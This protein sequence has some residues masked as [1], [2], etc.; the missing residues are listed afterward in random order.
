MVELSRRNFLYSTIIASGQILLGVNPNHLSAQYACTSTLAQVRA[1]IVSPQDYLN[2][3]IMCLPE[4]VESKNS[5]MLKG[6]IYQPSDEY[7]DTLLRGL[8]F[9][10]VGDGQELQYLVQSIINS[11]KTIR[12]KELGAIIPGIIGVFGQG[13]PIYVAFE[14]ELISSTEINNDADVRSVIRHELQHVKD[15]YKCITLGEVHLS[16]DTISSTTFRINF[17]EQL[18]EVRGIYIELEDIFRESVKTGR[19]SVSPQ[20]FGGQASNYA[21]HYQ[22]IKN[23]PITDLERRVSQLQIE[24]SKGITPEIRKNQIIIEFNLFGKRDSAE[25]VT[26]LKW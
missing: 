25:I 2:E 4:V 7:L 11:Y 15:W 1:G 24:E 19:V 12:G 3:R 5:G 18:M 10:R 6:F 20:W 22:F 14:K 23:E 8:F 21:E 9:G 26:N 13:I 17:L 16:Y